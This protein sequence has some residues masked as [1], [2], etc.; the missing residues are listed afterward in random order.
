VIFLNYFPNGFEEIELI[1]FIARYQYLKVTDS[2]YFFS[3]NR[4]YRER[5]RRLIEKKYLRK[6]KNNLVL[7]EIGI[8]YC[9]LSNFK[10]NKRN[11]NVKY[12]P[13]LLYLSHLA[14]L[15]HNSDIVRFKPSFD[16]KDKQA[17]TTTSRRFIGIFNIN[18]IEYLTYAIT[19]EHDKKYIK[20]VIYDIQKEMYYKNI[21]ILV[22][23]ISR[24]NIDEFTFGTNQVLVI[25]D[26]LENME[27]LKYLN[28]VDWNKILEE[29]YKNK[30]FLSEYNFCDYT[31]YN[32]K[33]ISTFYFLD[34]EKINRIKYFLRENKNRNIDIICHI[35]LKKELQKELPTAHYITVYLEEYIEK[36]RIYYA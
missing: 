14:T 7:A 5:I 29:N 32:S 20:S 19:E 24:I 34:T 26:T 3:S 31:D 15:Y 12:L 1:K 11:R 9:M 8:E 16:I 21:I 27:K 36:E 13:R 28:S 30:V 33:Y 25:E 10:Y 6:V 18:G 2:K 17:F 23:D 4:Y 22:N 35:K